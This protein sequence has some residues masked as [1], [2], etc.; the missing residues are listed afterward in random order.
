MARNIGYLTSKKTPES[1]NCFTPEFVVHNIAK[2]VPKETFGCKLM[3]FKDTP[4]LG[5]YKAIT[6]KTKILC[7]F[8]KDEHAFP[9]VFNELGFDVI[10]THFDPETGEGKDFFSYTKEDM[11]QLGIDYII[12]NPPF[13]LKNEILKHCYC[14][15]IPYALLLPLPTLQS[16]GRFNDVFSKG[17]TQVLIFDKRIPYSTREKRWEEIGM[18]NHFASIFICRGVLPK[19]LI[20][21]ELVI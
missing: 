5:D 13:S 6:K 14:L 3:I 8:D 2:Y 20:F 12:S 4:E 9:K 18:T 10:N 15:D 11:C 1:D 17:D 21:N 16:I 7:P 19:D